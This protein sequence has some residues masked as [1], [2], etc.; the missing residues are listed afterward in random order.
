M[1]QDADGKKL[2]HKMRWVNLDATLRI[3]KFEEVDYASD[4]VGEAI[5]TGPGVYDYSVIG[6]GV[7]ER[8]GDRGE[9]VYLFVVNGSLAC[10]GDATITSDVTLSVYMAAQDA[11][12]D[13][14][15]DEGEVPICMGTSDFGSAQRIPQ[16]PR[17]EPPPE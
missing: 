11:D 6:Y 1:P 5:K 15:P 3:P 10:E 8:P 17:C 7:N 9:I 2:T 14:L 12:M 13:G 16:M 4:L